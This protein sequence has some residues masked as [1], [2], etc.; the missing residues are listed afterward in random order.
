MN[1]NPK[2]EIQP[3][4]TPKIKRKTKKKRYGS[5]KR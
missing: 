5:P 2:A 4:P 3:R 1:K